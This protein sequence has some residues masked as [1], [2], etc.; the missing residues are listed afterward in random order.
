MEKAKELLNRYNAGLAT[1]EEK[2]IVE[3]WYLNY[4]T[5]PTDLSPEELQDEYSIG[6]GQL[7]RNVGIQKVVKIW[8]RIAV[9]ASIIICIGTGL[10]LYEHKK[11]ISNT[12]DLISKTQQ[13]V[14]ENNKA[15]L[16]LADGSEIILADAKEGKL[17]N[18]MG[19]G[20]V[21]KTD[22]QLVYADQDKSTT[23]T[24]AFNT[25][26]TPR[27]GQYQLQLPDGTKVW[28]NSV[29]SIKYPAKFSEKERRIE[30]V[31]EAYFEVAKQLVNGKRVPF[32]VATNLQQIKVL[33]THFNIKAYSNDDDAR[34]TLLE[35]SVMVAKTDLASNRNQNILLKPGEQAIIKSKGNIQVKSVD[36][37]EAIA[38][39]NGYFVFEDADIQSIMES[40]SRWY[41]IDVIYKGEIT[42]HKFGGAF[43]RTSNIN[44]LL[45]HLQA[46]GDVSFKVEGRRIIVM[47]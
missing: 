29:S 37:S 36:V 7:E 1:P 10:Y 40:L 5:V 31:G 34:T 33:G 6:L 41:D 16:T 24:L 38:W 32:I 46:F 3:S 11:S 39:K 18:Q 12:N 26:S 35:G 42:K 14:K 21:K 15:V 30:L 20:I 23:T 8:P 45:K 22:G 19:V 4:E 44:D 28:L 13:T 43:P 17:A 9:A 25:L 2:A 47:P 27:G